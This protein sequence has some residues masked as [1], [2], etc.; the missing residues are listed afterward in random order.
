MREKLRNF[1]LRVKAVGHRRRLDQDLEDELAFHVAMREAKNQTEGS[2]LNDA[3]S[4]ARRQLGNVARLK[5]ACRELWTF[6]TLESFLQDLRYGVRMLRK[7]PGFTIVAILTLALGIGANT[8]LFSLTYQVLLQRLPVQHP[9]ELVILHCPG[10][11][12]GHNSSDS[13][14]EEASFSYPLYKELRDRNTVFSGLVAR[15]AISLSVAG[16]RFSERSSGELVSG[17]YFETLGVRPALGRL[18]TMQDETV[19][20]ADTVAVLSYGYWTRRFANNP[21]ILNKQLTVNG[22]ALTVVGV[23]QE[24]F[25]GVQ[26]GETTD[27]F[28]PVTMK[29]QIMP[30]AND[31]SNHKDWWLKVLGRLKP[32]LKQDQAQSAL[33]GPFHSILEGEI[34]LL[35]FNQKQIARYLQNKLIVE[36]GSHGRPILQN[37]AR[38]PLLFLIAMVGLILVIG[39][40]NLAS[41]LIAKGEARQQEIAVRL[42]LG[43]G[44]TRLLRQLLTE[45]LLL[46]VAGA[47]AGILVAEL[48]L[49]TVI[50]TVARGIGASGIQPHLDWRVLL[51]AAAVSVLTGLLFGLAPALRILRSAPRGALNEPARG[52]SANIANVRLRKWLMVFQVAMTVVLLAVA[53]LFTM[54]LIRLQQEDLGLR[55]D[56]LIQFSIAPGLSRYS[57][58][59]T[60][61]LADRL[62]TSI[63]ALPGVRSVSAAN[64]PI[65]SDSDRSSNVTP[66]GYAAREDEDTS[67]DRNYV[68]PSY[69]S[70]MGIGLLRGREFNEADTASS[71]KVAI[72]SERMA[73]RFFAGRDAVGM[74]FA[75]GAGNS[76]HPDME[77]VGVVAQSKHTNV[78]TKP[79]LFAYLP[80]AQDTELNELTF[81]VRSTQDPSAVTSMVTKTVAG[82]DSGLPVYH[83]RLLVDQINETV[84][85]DQL[86]A[87]LS[88]C[89]GLLAAFLAAIGLYGVMAYVVARRTR[90]IGVR[91][92]LGATRGNVSWLILREVVQMAAIGLLI[93]LGLSCITGRMV[94]SL[95]FGVS[96]NN[97]LVLILTAAVLIAVALLGGSLPAR[98]A[99]SVDPMV[100][101][102]YE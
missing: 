95:L 25:S 96:A 15:Y 24:G 94:Q 77:I 46:A 50:V 13:E 89:L 11:H 47:L 52:S 72:V 67:V 102:R 71:R 26:I 66:E 62:R 76:A 80:Y 41:L 63:A 70:T 65:F 44:R 40:A 60:I 83:L 37:G 81:Y 48:G 87:S 91:I 19:P 79:Q 69:F 14:G 27:I 8:A 17:N 43:A 6:A 53:G 57:P 45:S 59:Q 51:F 42:S 92:A 68:G 64:I 9:E 22:A 99:A 58:A 3:H 4:A 16:E 56:H 31:L 90:E 18:L 7:S 84:F 54:S 28:I 10:Y 20:G 39:C 35:N 82:F 49:R 2:N 85:S 78:R 32:G 23:A 74:H 100:A 101:L 36:P 93:G 1:W 75:F 30:G 29:I 38:E 55:P 34:P 98:K 12:P 61:A 21:E 88:V 86:M 97:P 5:E 73:Q 33:Q